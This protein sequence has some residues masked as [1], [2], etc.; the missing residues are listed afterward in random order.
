M[1][2][3][4]TFFYGLLAACGPDSNDGKGHSGSETSHQPT[5]L[6]D[7]GISS[8]VAAWER[9]GAGN[10]Y[11]RK[12]EVEGDYYSPSNYTKYPKEVRTLIR[13]AHLENSQCRGGSGNE[14]ATFL[15]CDRRQ[16]I[17]AEL[18]KKGWCWGGSHVGY[19]QHWLRCTDDPD[20]RPGQQVYDATY[21]KIA[22]ELAAGDKRSESQR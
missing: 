22:Q 5:S 15:A 17:I 12:N 20:Y 13:K 1:M 10:R 19:L 14:P 6:S 8:R 18:E 16:K 3:L 21:L 11:Q 9:A 4:S 2:I 7:A